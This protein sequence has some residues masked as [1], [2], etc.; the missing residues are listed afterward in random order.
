MTRRW[1]LQLGSNLPTDAVLHSA[2]QRLGGLGAVEVLAPPQ[3]LA[4]AGGQGPDYVNA[5]VSLDCPL[6]RE[7]LHPA[8]RQI[9]SDLGRDRNDPQRVAIDIDLL[10]LDEGHGWLADTRALAKGELQR[11]PTT[12]LLAQAQIDLAAR[13]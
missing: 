7:A 1:L 4:P 6:D 11:W 12:H 10:A 3:R 13:S 9:E 8:L 5:L 2:L